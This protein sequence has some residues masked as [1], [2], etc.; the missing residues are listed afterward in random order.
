MVEHDESTDKMFIDSLTLEN[1]I[2]MG[3]LR[4]YAMKLCY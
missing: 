4:K 1:A 3:F 2:K